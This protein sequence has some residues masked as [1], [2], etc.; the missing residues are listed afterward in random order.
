MMLSSAIPLVLA[1]TWALL[2]ESS[3]PVAVVLLCAL[4]STLQ[5]YCGP[6]PGRHTARHAAALGLGARK[7]MGVSG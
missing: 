7:S 1:A 6:C 5:G 3:Q 4:R 2:A